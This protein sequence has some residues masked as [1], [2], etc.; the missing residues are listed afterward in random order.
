MYRRGIR[1]FGVVLTMS[2][3]AAAAEIEAGASASTDAAPTATATSE[4]ETDSAAPATE[5]S[6]KLSF[7]GARRDRSQDPNSDAARFASVPYMQRFKPQ[8][9]LWEMGLFVGVFAPSF[10][11]NLKVPTTTPEAYNGASFAAGGRFAYFPLSFAGVEVEGMLSPSATRQTER[12]ALFYSARGHAVL[13]LPL[14]SIVPFA[15]IGGGVLGAVSG[16][17]GHDGDPLF[18]FGLGAKVPFSEHVSARLD[19]RDN[20]TQKRDEGD[21]T[22]T[23][24]FEVL[25]GATFTLGRTPPPPPK[26]SDFDGLYDS[27]DRCP[28]TPALTVDGCAIDSDGDGVVD[29]RDQC[30]NVAGDDVTGCLKENPDPDGDGVPTP[31]DRC[32]DVA[33][34]APDG[35]PVKDSDKDGFDDPV[36]KCPSEPETKNGFEDGDG[37]PDQVPEAVKK[38]TG[39]MRGIVFEQGK[40]KISKESNTT[41]DAA[42]QTLVDYPSIRIEVSGHTSSEGAPAVNQK[43]S[44]D[45]AA[46][47]RDYLV[48]K[49]IAPERV[50][51]RGAG[52]S[53]P[54]ADNATKAGREENRRIEFR[55]LS[56]P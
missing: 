46:A 7:A 24:H 43:L 52:A 36:D 25:L 55:V 30:P 1:S 45:R 44:E 21:G 12:S 42:Y 39:V 54:I 41:L 22:P 31:C 20:L 49:G 18:H 14:Y 29:D 26:D 48:G 38:F 40:A 34:V 8:A 19:L 13:Q 3:W 4:V 53:E 50:I 32:A 33:G 2:S 15:V 17:M 9:H 51:A 5:T 37:C 11:H 6:E 35:C 10:D 27:E 23:H 47:V 16:P 56:Q 28:E